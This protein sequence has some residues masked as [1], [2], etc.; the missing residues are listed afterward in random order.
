MNQGRAATLFPRKF[1]NRYPRR[2]QAFA[3]TR[4]SSAVGLRAAADRWTTAPSTSPFDMATS[5]SCNE[6]AKLL[7]IPIDLTPQ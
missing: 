5:A 6:A 2:A 3:A 4:C 7:L 1:S